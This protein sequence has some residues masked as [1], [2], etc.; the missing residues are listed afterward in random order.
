MNELRTLM[1]AEPYRKFCL[2]TEKQKGDNFYDTTRA[3]QEDLV[4][5]K[6]LVRRNTTSQFGFT[7]IPCKSMMDFKF[8]HDLFRYSYGMDTDI[9]AVKRLVCDYYIARN[10]FEVAAGET[11]E[12]EMEWN[13][14][15]MRAV[16]AYFKTYHDMNI[17][18]YVDCFNG[19]HYT[20]DRIRKYCNELM[21]GSICPNYIHKD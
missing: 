10:F 8:W 1:S 12:T 6:L 13:E 16:I 19:C 15:V 11:I 4:F 3:L 7:L 20:C 14:D 21:G 9:E 18:D 17:L 5:L 2:M